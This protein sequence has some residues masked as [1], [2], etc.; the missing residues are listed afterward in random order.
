MS[1]SVGF[2]SSSKGPLP[3][4]PELP[5]LSTS[6][7]S[8]NEDWLGVNS[9]AASDQ[10][11]NKD[12]RK[13]PSPVLSASTIT[14]IA[15][16]SPQYQPAVPSL[17]TQFNMSI[18]TVEGNV[19][20]SIHSI[21]SAFDRKSLNEQQDQERPLPAMPQEDHLHFQKQDQHQ[22]QQYQQH[23][24]HYDEGSDHL[25]NSHNDHDHDDDH[26][27][28]SPYIIDEN[29]DDDFFLNS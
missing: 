29:C 28:G 9:G 19:E 11:E 7:L 17:T 2:E 5:A 13:A 3:Q 1:G 12:S 25:K 23:Y 24:N 14:T 16:G 21:D 4:L 20:G 8:I 15:A 26:S 22:Y 10:N 27:T 18:V 6:V